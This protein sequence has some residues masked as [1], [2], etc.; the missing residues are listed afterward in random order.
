MDI[1]YLKL[2][3]RKYVYQKVY[4][5]NEF[6]NKYARMQLRKIKH[7]KQHSKVSIACPAHNMMLDAL[8]DKLKSRI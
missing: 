5:L 4:V 1:L 3:A 6:T 7:F 2:E 8:L